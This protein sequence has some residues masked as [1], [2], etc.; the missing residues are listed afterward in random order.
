MED[1]RAASFLRL[2]LAAQ[3]PARI[4]FLYVLQADNTPLFLRIIHSG[5]AIDL[6]EKLLQDQAHFELER[7]STFLPFLG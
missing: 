3:E 6:L 4:P 1:V 7:R 5:T 2:T